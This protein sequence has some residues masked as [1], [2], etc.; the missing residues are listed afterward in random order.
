M[1]TPR[2]RRR[3]HSLDTYIHAEVEGRVSTTKNALVIPIRETREDKGD[4]GGNSARPRA[5]AGQGASA[6][7]KRA[8]ARVSN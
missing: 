5:R 4:L 3:R 6:S 8:A 7:R 1:F 2:Q